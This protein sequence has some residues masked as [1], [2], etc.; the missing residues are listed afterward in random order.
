MIPL[1]GTL[2]LLG[3]L[4]SATLE[5]ITKATIQATLKSVRNG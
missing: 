3:I 1:Y 4:A 2:T 5:Y